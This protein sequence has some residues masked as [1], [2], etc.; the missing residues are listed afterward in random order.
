MPSA[1]C[2]FVF[3]TTF[4]DAFLLVWLLQFDSSPQNLLLSISFSSVLENPSPENQHL[5]EKKFILTDMTLG[6]RWLGWKKKK[7]KYRRLHHYY[8]HHRHHRHHTPLPHYIKTDIKPHIHTTTSHHTNAIYRSL[9]TLPHHHRSSLQSRPTAL[10]NKQKTP[11]TTPPYHT[12]SHH[13]SSPL[14]SVA[15][16]MKKKVYMK[17]RMIAE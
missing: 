9:H 16:E 10:H 4:L 3:F 15:L 7:R 5:E 14:L 2:A 6:P 8:H 11:R 13:P 17:G 12:T 1:N